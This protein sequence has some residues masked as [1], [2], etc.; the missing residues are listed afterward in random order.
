VGF[1][2]SALLTLAEW[3]LVAR[4]PDLGA[5][6]VYLHV[7]AFGPVLTSGFWSIVN[8][9]F[10]PRSAKRE[11][12]RIAGVGTLGGLAGGLLAERLTAWMGTSGTLP[13]LALARA[14]CAWS[15]KGLPAPVAGV[16]ARPETQE[17]LPAGEAGRRLRTTPYLRNLALLVLG[18]SVSAALLDFVFKA[19]ASGVARQSLD[20]MRVFSAF[21]ALVA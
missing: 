11:I 8:E 5:I 12:G 20:L 4:R 19:Q 15:T 2:V 16:A 17:T 21:Y 6:A 13:A 7:A 3:A 14:W 9:R 10:D 1:F 18:S